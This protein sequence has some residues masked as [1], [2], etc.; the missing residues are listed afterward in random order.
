MSGKNWTID[1]DEFAVLVNGE[2]QHSLWP[3]AATVP[4]GWERMGPL[5]TKAECLAFV[6]EHW[7]DMRPTSLQHAMAR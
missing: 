7:T 2:G 5:G 4:E 1:G 6:E 3:S